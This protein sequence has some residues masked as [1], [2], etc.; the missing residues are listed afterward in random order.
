[1]ITLA[2]KIIR[3]IKK[4]ACATKYIFRNFELRRLK[5]F[6]RFIET[7]TKIF[8]KKFTVVD[9]PSFVS[10]YKEIFLHDIYKFTAD[11][12]TPYILDCGANV[13]VSILYFKKMYPDCEII[14]FEPDKKIFKVLQKNVTT[15]NLKN[16]TL[17]EKALWDKEV[18]LPFFDE[19]ADGGRIPNGDSLI[20]PGHTVDAVSLK[21]FLDK[22]VDFLKIDVEGVEDVILKD[23]EP[24]LK[25]VKNLFVEY[26]SFSNKNQTLQDIL[27]ILQ[28]A[29]FRY[30]IHNVGIKS[31]TPFVSVN[32]SSLHFDNQLNISAYRTKKIT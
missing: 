7:E 23:I 12:K 31:E 18:P 15:F 4:N 28:K 32:V 11:N 3:K 26:H 10:A 24:L 21:P 6:P 20:T 13:G 1:M 25:N 16:V 27:S 8:E 29:G 19:G 22:P 5:N 30:Y 2:K 14:G 9:A 17:L